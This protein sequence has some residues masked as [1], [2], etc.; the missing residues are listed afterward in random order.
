MKLQKGLVEFNNG[1][2]ISY[3]Q[4][5]SQLFNPKRYNWITLQ[6]FN[7]EFENDRAMQGI[8][9]VI[10]LFCCGLSIRI[11]TH[12]KE[13]H[14]IHKEVRNSLKRLEQSCYGW[15]NKEDY[16]RYRT[17]K[18]DQIYVVEKKRRYYTKKIF[19]Q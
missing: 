6:L 1:I 19:I 4:Q 15:V 12:P 5:I 13:E 17:K 8:E 9:F 3:W 18:A 2:I 14:K 16:E 11:P 7:L 10:V